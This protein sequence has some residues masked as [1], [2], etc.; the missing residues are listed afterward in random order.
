MVAVG[1]PGLFVVPED[2]GELVAADA[3]DDV[4]GTDDGL[5][6]AGGLSE[7]LVA[8]GMPKA[9]VVLLEIVDVEEQERDAGASRAA[10]S[11]RARRARRK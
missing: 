9:V 2:D 3:G 4:A 7:D 6:E 11:R 8:G 10:R 5:H 1:S